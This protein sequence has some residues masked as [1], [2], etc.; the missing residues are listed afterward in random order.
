MAGFT[1]LDA[2]DAKD[3]IADCLAALLLR[4]LTADQRE[5][6][7]SRCVR[8]ISLLIEAGNLA[9]AGGPEVGAVFIHFIGVLN[10]QA[11]LH[12]RKKHFAN[13]IKKLSLYRGLL[14]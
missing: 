12:D 1:L 7:V 13:L 8:P 10:A 3:V 6:V 5:Q 9:G 2:I 14:H 11:E 4:P